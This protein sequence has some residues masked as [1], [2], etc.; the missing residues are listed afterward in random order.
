MFLFN[1]RR[2]LFHNYRDV[3]DE[4][5]QNYQQCGRIYAECEVPKRTPQRGNRRK[6]PPTRITTT[7]EE[8]DVEKIS[9]SGEQEDETENDIN[10]GVDSTANDSA[11][12]NDGREQLSEWESISMGP[13]GKLI[14]RRSSAQRIRLRGN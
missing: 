10:N 12:Q 11:E 5:A 13:L 1:Y 7:T 8:P 6:V 9:F 2:D 14:Q 4:R 3:G